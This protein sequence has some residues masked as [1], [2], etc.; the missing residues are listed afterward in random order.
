MGM[1][2]V[3]QMTL[4]CARFLWVRRG[5]TPGVRAGLSWPMRDTSAADWQLG[6]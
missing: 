6:V 2:S 1:L 5:A 3:V 4:L